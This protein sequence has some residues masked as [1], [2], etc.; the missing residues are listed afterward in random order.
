[1]AEHTVIRNG[2]L[3]DTEPTPHVLTGRSTDLLITDG[4]LETVGEPV[5]PEQTLAARPGTI[6]EIDADGLIVLPGFVDT[7]RHTWQTA[8]RGALPDSTL[9]DYLRRILNGAGSRYLPADARDGNLT[10]ALEC[11]DAGITTLLDWSH[12]QHSPA[13]TEALVSGLADAGIRAVFGYAQDFGADPDLLP[14]EVR[15]VH[16][17][18]FDAAPPLVS[19]ALAALGPDLGT[20]ERVLAEWRVAEELDLPV[21]VHTGVSGAETATAGLELLRR[22]GLLRAGTTYVH[23]NAYTDEQ[24]RELADSGGRISVSPVS[25]AVLDLGYPPTGR[26]LAAGLP[27]SLSIDTVTSCPGDMFSQLRAA[28]QAERARPDGVGLGFT[29]ADALRLATIGGAEVL[30]MADRIG[31]LRPGKAADLVLLRTDT[32]GMTGQRD[33]IAATVLHAD[34]SAVD[35]VLVAGRVVKRDG[36]LLDHERA[37]LRDRLRAQGD[38]VLSGS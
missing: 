20:E 8:L 36:H 5:N 18:H 2:T 4:K 19:M 29:V 10:G 16:R 23:A 31:S 28:Y 6:E 35:T 37:D 24:L 26:A 22:H 11:L 21:T 17:E 7:H 27:T 25:E 13:H 32:L 1:M 33:P 38:R 30:G 34:S 14:A 12:L 9:P 15:R 3:I